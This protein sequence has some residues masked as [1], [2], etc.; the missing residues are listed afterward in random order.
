[1]EIP[2][3]FPVKGTQVNG[4]QVNEHK[5]LYINFPISISTRLLSNDS[6]Y[7]IV[8]DMDKDQDKENLV[9]SP[10]QVTQASTDKPFH[11]SAS[12]SQY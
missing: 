6:E 7:Q 8:K 1:V 11:S 2:P 9:L 12:V 4:H 5:Q 10:A 3:S